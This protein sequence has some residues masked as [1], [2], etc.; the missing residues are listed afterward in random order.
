MDCVHVIIIYVEPYI[1]FTE[2]AFWFSIV[3]YGLDLLIGFFHM[4]MIMFV[5]CI[6]NSLL[7]ITNLENDIIEGKDM[8]I[9]KL[10]YKSIFVIL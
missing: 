7:F 9:I 1:N 10:E 6:T 3:L 8:E 5:S 4:L 2:D